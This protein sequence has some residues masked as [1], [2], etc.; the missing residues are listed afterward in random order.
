MTAS[1]AKRRGRAICTIILVLV[2]LLRLGAQTADETPGD[3]LQQLRAQELAQASYDELLIEAEQ[4]GLSL[5]GSRSELERRILDDL[6]IEAHTPADDTADSGQQTR[7][8][9]AHEVQLI[10]GSGETGA[11]V[12]LSGGVVIRLDDAETGSVH[13]I[14][15]DN[16]TINREESVVSASGGVEYTVDRDG[17]LERF[18]GDTLTVELESWAGTFLYGVSTRPRAIEGEDFDFRFSGRTISRSPDDVIIIDEGTITSSV[19]DPPNYRITAD[20]IWILDTGDW[21]LQNA[22]LY[23]GRVPMFW[24]PVF[25]HPGRPMFLHPAI[26]SRDG[27]GAFVQTTVYL[28]GAREERSQPLSV[29]QLAEDDRAGERVREG[30]FLRPA[31]DDEGSVI[32][33]RTIRLFTD[34][35]STGQAFFALDARLPASGVWSETS[36]F[37]GAGVSRVRVAAPDGSVA[38]VYW[39]AARQEFVQTSWSRSMFPGIDIPLRFGMNVETGLRAGPLRLNLQFPFYSDAVFERDYLNRGE[40]IDWG[41]IIG[42]SDDETD[43]PSAREQL[44][45]RLQGSFNPNTQGLQPLLTQANID[46][47]NT[48]LS[49]RRRAIPD[50]RL[51]PTSSIWASP[52][53]DPPGQSFYYPERLIL[54]GVSATLAGTLLQYPRRQGTPA[55]ELEPAEE[56]EPGLRSPFATDGSHPGHER[57]PDPENGSDERFRLPPVQGDLSVTRPE[58][59]FAGELS[60]RISPTVTVTGQYLSSPWQTPDDVDY[61]IE[62]WEQLQR[63]QASMSWRASYLSHLASAQGST[64]VSDRYRDVFGISPL[65]EDSR[66]EDLRT[67]AFGE[68]STVIDNRLTL[69]SSPLESRELFAG[70]EISYFLDA[71]LLQRRFDRF[72]ASDEPVYATEL[73]E[74]DRDFVQR[75]ALQLASTL[76]VLQDRQTLTLRLDLPP[77]QERGSSE[78]TVRTGIIQSGLR[79]SYVADDVTGQRS[80]DPVRFTQSITPQP[81]YR[82]AHEWTYDL[83]AAR[84]ETGRLDLQLSGLTGRLDARRSESFSFDTLNFSWVGDDTETFRPVQASLGYNE[85]FDPLVFWRNRVRLTPSVQSSASA[86]L[87]RYTSSSLSFRLNLE[88]DIHQ[89]LNLRFSSQSRNEQLFRY[90]GPYARQLGLERESFVADLLSSF[91]FFDRGA[92]EDSAF[93]LGQ[94]RIDAVHDLGDWDLTI[95]YQGSP[96]QQSSPDGD[97]IEWQGTVELLLQWRPIPEISRD[98]TFSDDEITW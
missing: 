57:E 98:L 85:S 67:R 40:F 78:L 17:D 35:Y 47:V 25:F 36:V 49:W 58:D 92:R 44:L 42:F 48:E 11:L 19:S 15:A 4:R 60:Y 64:S 68:H 51:D 22:V 3:R 1:V 86:N 30:L 9:Q 31:L 84:I 80:V 87:L 73:V 88:L 52:P 13:T 61:E 16:I 29:L 90:V 50:A 56:P 93:K 82:L 89:F 65:V 81:G 34:V 77:R 5:D 75:H 43:G 72:S 21:G 7:I 8:Q 6:G 55:D 37:A 71:R 69:R 74:W 91:Y 14:S 28:A 12:R 45:W 97:T 39:D 66:R 33:D 46:S 63:T 10:Q 53:F 54:P 79:I 70:S 32:H 83:D 38:T 96:Q 2:S 41:S 94:L 18:T 59:P 62:Y 76:N 26:G 24:F 95:G 20:R 27:D 23:V